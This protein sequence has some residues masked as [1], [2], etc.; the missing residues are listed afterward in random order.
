MYGRHVAT[1]NGG[2]D[3]DDDSSSSS[4]DSPPPLLTSGEDRRRG[5]LGRGRGGFSD[6]DD[7]WAD[8]DDDKFDDSSDSSDSPPELL[9]ANDS[10]SDEP[11]YEHHDTAA[12]ATGARGGGGDDSSDESS[13]GSLPSLHHDVSDSDEDSS[14]YTSDGGDDDEGFVHSDSDSFYS[15]DDAADEGDNPPE[16]LAYSDEDDSDGPPELFERVHRGAARKKSSKRK[17][18]SKRKQLR[19]EDDLYFKFES[20][21]QDLESVLNGAQFSFEQLA[22][23]LKFPPLGLEG[24]VEFQSMLLDDAHLSD[25]IADT[26]KLKWAR[27]KLTYV[28]KK[29]ADSAANANIVAPKL[30]AKIPENSGPSF[31]KQYEPIVPNFLRKNGSLQLFFCLHG[32]DQIEVER[33][34]SRLDQ[35]PDLLQGTREEI[36][37]ERARRR[38]A[39]PKE[40]SNCGRASE[41]FS[42]NYSL[43]HCTSCYTASYCDASCQRAHWSR[44]R[45]VNKPPSSYKYYDV[46]RE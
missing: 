45:Y 31:F 12:T 38:Q 10:D 15:D 26:K 43:K 2:D 13:N 18:K 24:K 16:L 42:G 11:L 20:E 9:D 23:F 27:E 40:C 34:I 5:L 41:Y 19:P 3:D 36:E 39:A 21:E 44:H 6:S 33:C 37:E 35:E 25:H 29:N 32:N 14:Y 8:S 30:K 46:G 4:Q 22:S 1:S 28:R 7:G 17:K